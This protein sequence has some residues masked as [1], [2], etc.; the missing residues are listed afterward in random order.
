LPKATK[1]IATSILLR[2]DINQSYTYSGKNELRVLRSHHSHVDHEFQEVE[3]ES[4]AFTDQAQNDRREGEYCERQ[5]KP[6]VEG[7]AGS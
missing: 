1:R 4:W 3:S 7:T 6:Y 2:R 5:V